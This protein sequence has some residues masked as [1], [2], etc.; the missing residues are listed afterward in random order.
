M[1][2]L[3]AYAFTKPF[4]EPAPLWD[5]WPWL[6]LPLCMGISIVYKAIRCADMK[7]VPKEA[8]IVFLW[9]IGVMVAVAA[10]LMILV[11]LISR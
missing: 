1:I 7:R 3:L 4:I 2:P 6:A 8:A 5:Y 9:I 10:G 11:K